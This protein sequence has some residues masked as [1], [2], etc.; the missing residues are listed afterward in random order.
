MQRREWVLRLPSWRVNLPASHRLAFSGEL[1]RGD[2]QPA[3]SLVAGVDAVITRIKRVSE[4][5]GTQL[6]SAGVLCR[7]PLRYVAPRMSVC[8]RISRRFPS[9]R[10]TQ[11]RTGTR[12]PCSG[13][14]N[15]LPRTL[16]AAPLTVCLG[17][18]FSSGEVGA[19]M[20]QC[21]RTWRGLLQCLPARAFGA[22]SRAAWFS[23]DSLSRYCTIR[24]HAE[25]SMI[26]GDQHQKH[27]RL[28][29]L[30]AGR[31]ARTTGGLHDVYT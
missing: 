8:C 15:R 23:P 20:K 18:W 29:R 16:I 24:S 10:A 14:W 6:L 26:G 3:V 13:G 31:H 4:R 30:R 21:C 1:R 25:D 19:S 7:N 2:S 5:L 17:S 12:L 11:D 22:E 27:S 28:I 9:L